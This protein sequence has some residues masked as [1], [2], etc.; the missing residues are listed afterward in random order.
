MNRDA[1]TR[2][3]VTAA[4]AALLIVLPAACGKSSPANPTTTAAG[5][6]ALAYAR[7]MRDNGVPDFPDPNPNGQ[8]PGVNRKY[9]GDPAFQ[10][11]QRACRNRASGGEHNPADPAYVPQLRKFAQCMRQHGLPQFPDP[12]ADGGFPPGTEG[13]RADPNFQTALT[14]C[15]AKLPGSIAQH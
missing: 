13:L 8:F 7:C 1:R 2:R 4:A 3:P 6:A 14:A 11:A 10:T 12:N 9:Q 15:Y 5:Q